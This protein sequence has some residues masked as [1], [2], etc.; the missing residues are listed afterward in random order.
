MT[1]L[2]VGQRKNALLN[3][4]YPI[5]IISFRECKAKSIRIP[6]T[7]TV[8][9]V[10]AFESLYICSVAATPLEPAPD[11]PNRPCVSHLVMLRRARHISNLNFA[12]TENLFVTTAP[13][14]LT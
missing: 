6:V 13:K 1:I 8:S 9:A 5:I 2:L 7:F 10:I 4:Y 3:W 11:R 14:L 12:I